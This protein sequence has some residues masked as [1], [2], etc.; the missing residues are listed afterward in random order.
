[1]KRALGVILLLGSAS[2][3]ACATSGGLV[4][5]PADY[6]S[7]SPEIA[8]TT[9]LEAV[10]EEDYTVMGQQF[11]TRKGPAE[12]RMGISEVEQRMVVLA[13]LLRHRSHQLRRSDLAR[14]GEDRRRFM[15]RLSGT[16][17]G[18]VEVPIVAVRSSE[19]RWFIQQIDVDPLTGGQR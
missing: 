12:E 19:G 11:G 2:L 14:L 4:G 15:V 1:M 7:A 6:G 5:N 16:Q 8:V 17:N 10:Q 13:G 9:F 3:A 18:T